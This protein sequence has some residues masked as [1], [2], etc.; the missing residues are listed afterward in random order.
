M[1]HVLRAFFLHKSLAFADP[2][3]RRALVQLGIQSLAAAGSIFLGLQEAS[4]EA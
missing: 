3:S 2:L 1:S 4:S